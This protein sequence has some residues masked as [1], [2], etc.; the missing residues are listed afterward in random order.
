[1]AQ[2]VHVIFTG[3]A[4]RQYGHLLRRDCRLRSIKGISRVYVSMSLESAQ[5]QSTLTQPK[6][7]KLTTRDAIIITLLALLAAVAA[8]K[9]ADLVYDTFGNFTTRKLAFENDAPVMNR[10]EVRVFE[11]QQLR[12]RL[13]IA[14]TM[15]AIWAGSVCGA[16][17]AGLGTIRRGMVGAGIGFLYATLL[18]ITLGF[19]GGVAGEFLQDRYRIMPYQVE[20]GALLRV[21]LF[22]S[23]AFAAFSLA[24]FAV[25]VLSAPLQGRKLPILIGAVVAAAVSSLVYLAVTAL[26]TPL[27]TT[28]SFVPSDSIC[29]L[30]WFTS[31]A[32]LVSL[33]A[34]MLAT[35]PQKNAQEALAIQSATSPA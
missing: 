2:D 6:A 18:G 1:M 5:D 14:G 8:W 15:T 25:F 24:V 30:I 3:H 33:T 9:P 10:E 12:F 7:S 35:V 31:P 32:L 21:I 11:N 4:L 34:G 28:W 22:Q 20:W 13:T 16:M 26:I 17:G 19:L 23:V 27:A 29:R